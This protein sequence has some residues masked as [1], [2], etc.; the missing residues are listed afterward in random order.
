MTA[1]KS[2]LTFLPK[3][4]FF[5]PDIKYSLHPNLI[6]PNEK[7]KITNMNTIEAYV[8]IFNKDDSD[9]EIIKKIK[10]L[11]YNQGD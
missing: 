5:Y 6:K 7:V 11:K 10:H 8:I 2:F 3:T 9:E 4:L 1:Q